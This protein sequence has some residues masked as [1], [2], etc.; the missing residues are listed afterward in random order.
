M[1]N[2][3]VI[4]Y[5]TGS[6]YLK[7]DGAIYSDNGT[8]HIDFD[9]EGFGF[10]VEIKNG[11]ITLRSDGEIKYFVDFGEKEQDVLLDTPFGDA[12]VKVNVEKAEY[13][14]SG[15]GHFVSLAFRF[16]GKITNE[17]RVLEIRGK[18]K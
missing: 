7:T 14:K 8:L 18:L 2:N 6:S 13:R 16:D 12:I 15:D 10:F 3:A 4:Y 5:S 11:L 1:N 17:S 9:G